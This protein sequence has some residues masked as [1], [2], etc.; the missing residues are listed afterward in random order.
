MRCFTLAAAVLLTLIGPLPA[1]A[2]TQ[3]ADAFEAP[4]DVPVDEVEHLRFHSAFWV[5]LH[6]TLY[7]AA[8]SRRPAATR[9]IQLPPETPAPLNEVDRAAWDAAIA[10]YDREIADRDLRSG[11]G[12]TRI[13][14][15]LAAGELTSPAMPDELRAVLRRAAPIYRRHFWAAHDRTN[16]DWIADTTARLRTIARDITAALARLYERPWFQAPVRIDIVGVGGRAYSTLN[17]TTHATVSTAEGPLTGWT[18]VDIVLH[19]V[20]HELILGIEERLAAALGDRL[21]EHDGLW[22]VVQF[23]VTGAALQEVLRARGIEYVP[24]LYS[25]GLF[26]RAWSKYRKPIEEHWAPYVRGSGTRA[27]AIEGTVAALTGK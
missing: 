21:K 6:H 10:Y 25:T 17:P 27:Q 18:S 13:K 4:R 8:W 7:G 16:R 2:Q 5:N 9:R 15:A 12:M 3:S 19:E 22:H 20:S 11:P 26:D 23:Y 24:Y 14:L 1:P